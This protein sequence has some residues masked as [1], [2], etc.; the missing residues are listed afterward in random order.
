VKLRFQA[1]ADLNE[2]IVKGVLRRELGIDFQTVT[3]AGLRGL[4]DLEVLAFAA[5]EGR[6]LVSHDRKTMPQTFGKFIHGTTSPGLFLISQKTD[7][8]IAIEC[9]LLAW[10]A[11][12][13]E[14][15]INR[16]VAIPF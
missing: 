2:D 14:E 8:L 16:M 1:D 6:I 3:S 10:I 11:S 9:V 7:L 13:H 5:V 15:W 4:S 12:D